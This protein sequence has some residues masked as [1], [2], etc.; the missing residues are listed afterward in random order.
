MNLSVI[1]TVFNGELFLHE[2]IESIQNQTFS[3]FEL[4]ILNDGSTDG[5]LGVIQRYAK[6][7]SRI[8]LISRE[9]KGRIVSL[10]ECISIS[11]GEFIAIMDA[12]D[13]SLPTRFEKQIELL[14]KLKA[15]FCGSEFV[16]FNSKGIIRK[17]DVP[18][19]NAEFLF[20]LASRLPFVNSSLI[21][22]REYIKNQQLFY[23]MSSRSIIVEDY[24]FCAEAYIRGGIF[25][26]VNEVLVK[27]RVS[28]NSYS[29]ENIRKAWIDTKIVSQNFCRLKRNEILM[30][31]RAGKFE[32]NR[33][34]DKL[35]TCFLI[36]MYIF[37]EKMSLNFLIT[38]L[39]KSPFIF[40]KSFIIYKKYYNFKITT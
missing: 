19:S 25:V 14:H 3:D 33:S 8:K 35:N 13:I 24:D 15:D 34:R 22:R 29:S 11:N 30:E 39:C 27:Y 21:F 18:F 20:F 38:W 31:L 5:S 26:N 7:D 10:N 2:A 12:D 28:S 23:G 37:G 17:Y 36:A 32:I 6:I 16:A 9:N 40:L 1:M 4:L